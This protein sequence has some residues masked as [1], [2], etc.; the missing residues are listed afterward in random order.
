M[1]ADSAKRTCNGLR[2]GGRERWLGRVGVWCLYIVLMMKGGCVLLVARVVTLWCGLGYAC[3]RGRGCAFDVGLRR[4]GAV[5]LA[6][7]A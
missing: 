4:A 5:G 6:A 1:T 3:G 7:T 2:K